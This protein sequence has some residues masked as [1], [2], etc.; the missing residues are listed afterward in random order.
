MIVEI[1]CGACSDRIFDT[2]DAPRVILVV[3]SLINR[4]SI[5][6]NSTVGDED[7]STRECEKE[8]DMCV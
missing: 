6:D 3:Y 4:N 7:N 1:G 5:L 8:W 2:V